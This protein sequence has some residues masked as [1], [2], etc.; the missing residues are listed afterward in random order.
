MDKER[1]GQLARQITLV[2]V[3]IAGVISI[4]GYDVPVIAENTLTAV[5]SAILYVC[6][7]AWNHYK[8]NDYTIEGRI[9]TNITRQLKEDRGK[10]GSGNIENEDA[11]K[12]E[13]DDP[14]DFGG[15]ING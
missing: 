4:L 3:A 13:L 6:V 8:N 11:I 10:Y 15:C 14:N 12:H 5:I 1:I 2:I 7:L 9:G